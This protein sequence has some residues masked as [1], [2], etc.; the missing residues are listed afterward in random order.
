MNAWEAISGGLGVAVG[1]GPSRLV[2]PLTPDLAAPPVARVVEA[3]QVAPAIALALI[4]ASVLVGVALLVGSLWWWRSKTEAPG[5]GAF[6]RLSGRMGLRSDERSLVC[7]LARER[8]MPP[9]ALLV[10]LD[11]LRSLLERT[12]PGGDEAA[13]AW[14]LKRCVTARRR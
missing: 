9:V 8:G 10:S 7:A 6:R 4:L 11:T 5:D 3:T 1:S 14:L 2:T 13:R 12:R